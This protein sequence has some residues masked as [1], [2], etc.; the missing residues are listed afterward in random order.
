MYNVV[1]QKILAPRSPGKCLGMMERKLRWEAKE[2]T[3]G[4]L[5]SSM[6]KKDWR[7]SFCSIER[8]EPGIRIKPKKD[9]A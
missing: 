4:V 8:G 7:S 9:F 1:G 5:S 3:I 6:G 2:T